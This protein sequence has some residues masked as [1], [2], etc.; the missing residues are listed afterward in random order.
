MTNSEIQFYLDILHSEEQNIYIG[1]AKLYC[2][3]ELMRFTNITILRC[4]HNFISEIPY[5]PLTLQQLYCN[6]NTLSSLH[7][8]P[9]GLLVLECNKNKL[10]MLPHLPAGLHIL[11]CDDNKLVC[12]PELPLSNLVYL[13]CIR[14]PFIEY[15]RNG[16]RVSIDTINEVNTVIRRFRYLYYLLKYKWKFLE[17]ISKIKMKPE[18]IAKWLENETLSLEWDKL[19]TFDML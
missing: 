5:L 15:L 2:M 17:I 19:D 13:S 14:N 9:N 7:K 8:L 18:N 6:N 4:S 16:H 10:Q 11:T 3:P 1:F 12:L